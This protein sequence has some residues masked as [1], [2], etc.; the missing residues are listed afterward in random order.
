MILNAFWKQTSNLLYHAPPNTNKKYNKMKSRRTTSTSIYGK[1]GKRKQA[2][3]NYVVGKYMQQA[4]VTRC[5]LP[6]SLLIVHRY[7]LFL[8][9]PELC[10][11]KIKMI[12]GGMTS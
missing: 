9:I 6:F 1:S 5:L 7:F 2:L 10:K 3:G 11:N 12:I 4:R 8:V